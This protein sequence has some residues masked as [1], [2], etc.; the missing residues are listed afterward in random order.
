MKLAT[1]PLRIFTTPAG[2]TQH[3]FPLACKPSCWLPKLVW[4][5]NSRLHLISLKEKA[6]LHVMYAINLSDWWMPIP[7]DLCHQPGY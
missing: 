7:Y 3:T 5:Q 6:V 4:R 1:C 2:R